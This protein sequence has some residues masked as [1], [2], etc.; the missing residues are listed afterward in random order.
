V[1]RSPDH[2]RASDEAIEWL[3]RLRATDVSNAEQG[4]FAQWLATHPLHKI[5]FDDAL[6]LWEELGTL[7]A[8]VMDGQS[9]SG[10][11]SASD[12]QSESSAQWPSLA[13]AATILLSVLT[14]LL[15]QLGGNE[16]ETG[17]GEQR[18]VVLEDGSSIHL[19]TATVA[20]VRYSRARRAVEMSTGEA[21]F[22][23]ARDTDRPFLVD[24]AQGR[25]EVVGTAF[26]VYASNSATRLTVAE[27]K[28]RFTANSGEQT[29]LMPG[30]RVRI[31]HQGIERSRVERRDIG[32]WMAGQLEYDDV[33][34]S[35]LIGDLNRYFPTRMVLSDPTLG[36]RHVVAS[37]RLEDQE[38]VLDTLNETL[39]LSWHEISDKL[40]IISSSD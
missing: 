40:I 22:D 15:L 35:D 21:Y 25:I 36:E 16:F 5:A 27:G 28:V 18:R 1:K 33:T 39:G 37:L 12:G 31:T 10:E 32:T 34:L 17:I 13:A 20:Q 11:R 9:A 23:V 3:A 29:M 7:P 6:A 24:T 14:L 38:G 4:D 30:Q 2:T 19:N 26:A 8:D